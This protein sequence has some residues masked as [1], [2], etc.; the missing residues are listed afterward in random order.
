MQKVWWALARWAARRVHADVLPHANVQAVRDDLC[1]L[2]EYAARS[3]HL[4]RGFKAGKRV[5][6]HTIA[7]AEQLRARD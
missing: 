7:C 4:Q 2:S 3:G 1:A 6:A 5:V